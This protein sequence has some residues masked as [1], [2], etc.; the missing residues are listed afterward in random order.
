[1]V[2][3][4][5]LLIS[6][7]SVKQQKNR[8]KEIA[9]QVLFVPITITVLISKGKPTVWKRRSSAAGRLPR[10]LDII[11]MIRRLFI[12]PLLIDQLDVFDLR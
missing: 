2:I 12:V 4:P 9:G 3:L 11:L 10:A 8:G 6:F 5:V 1:M 7:L